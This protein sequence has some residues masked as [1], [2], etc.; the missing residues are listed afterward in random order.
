MILF[1]IKHFELGTLNFV[2][3]LVLVERLLDI[4][5]DEICIGV[6]LEVITVLRL[7]FIAAAQ[8]S[9]L[10]IAVVF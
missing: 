1:L 10:H 9:I 3:G 6:I 5:S 8:I 7:K 4:L 2:C